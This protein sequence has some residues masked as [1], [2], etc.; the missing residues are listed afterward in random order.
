MI[1]C[2][3]ASL[4]FTNFLQISMIIRFKKV[5]QD[6]LA[7]LQNVWRCAI[8]SSLH[9]HTRPLLFWN[10]PSSHPFFLSSLPSSQPKPT[11][12]LFAPP[13]A[14][15][16][17][18]F[19]PPHPSAHLSLFLPAPFLFSPSLTI[20]SLTSSLG[21]L[22]SALLIPPTPPIFLSPLPSP[23]SPILPLLPVPPRPS[24]LSPIPDL[25]L[26]IPL[27]VPISRSSA[28]VSP[29]PLHALPVNLPETPPL[30]WGAAEPSERWR[31]AVGS[32]VPVLSAPFGGE[33]AALGLLG[34]V[35]GPGARAQCRG[36]N[37]AGAVRCPDRAG[38]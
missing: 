9:L 7:G 25:Y 34:S 3:F 30:G 20:P 24:P 36:A 17:V 26:V 13:P 1:I 33:M 22:P 29:T 32:R 21:V 28:A 8:A 10:S 31:R 16:L 35:V 4:C 5:A 2:F 14:L 6:P 18:Q 27:L 23:P 38:R 11:S 19:F 37:L 15:F 12:T